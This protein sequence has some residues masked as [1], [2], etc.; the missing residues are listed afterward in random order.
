MK[1]GFFPVLKEKKNAFDVGT[2]MNRYIFSISTEI[3]NN[4]NTSSW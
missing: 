4:H 1:I 2:Y 3:Q